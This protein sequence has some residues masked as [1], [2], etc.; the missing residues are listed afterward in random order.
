MAKITQFV[1]GHKFDTKM[2]LKE[3]VQD[4][5]NS[6]PHRK[7]LSKEHFDFMLEILDRHPNSLEKVGLGVKFMDIRENGYGK[8][9]RG[10]WIVRNDDTET[11]FSYLKC[12]N[13]PTGHN[14]F[15][16]ACRKIVRPEI[17]RFRDRFF[18]QAR[19]PTCPITGKNVSPKSC[20]VDHAPPLTFARIVSGFISLYN[21]NVD[22]PSI[23]NP[24]ED[25]VIGNNLSN[26]MMIR[27]FVTFHNCFASLR[28][29]SI[30]AN[31]VDVPRY[32]REK[33]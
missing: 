24:S 5:L 31:T 8:N 33:S 21:V 4:I 27:D 10:F 26:K 19:T 11:D 25:G 22:D 3:Y 29:T 18:E 7:P 20:H 30:E 16:S 1:N 14:I 32:I 23:F 15:S 17:D 28:V 12:L 2:A 13:P 6:Y 9:S